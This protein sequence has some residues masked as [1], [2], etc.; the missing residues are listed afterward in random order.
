VFYD[1]STESETGTVN[2]F[3]QEVKQEQSISFIEAYCNAGKYMKTGRIF[4]YKAVIAGN[5]WQM[6]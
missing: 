2:K 4:R 3:L 5:A 6:P 1:Y